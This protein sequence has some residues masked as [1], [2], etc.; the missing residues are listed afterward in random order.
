MIDIE[1]FRNLIEARE[2]KQLRQ[3]INTLEVADLAEIIGGLQ[4]ER[5]FIIAFRL[6]KRL[7]RA[8]V[9][10]NLPADSQEKL[11]AIF[12]D[13]IISAFVEEM[14][15]DD[16]TRLLE[17]V[18]SE[19]AERFIVG[20]SPNEQRIARM[21]LSYPADS[22][23]RLMT[24]DFVT[25]KDTLDVA[26]ALAQVRWVAAGLD[27]NLLY[28]ILVTDKHGIYRGSLSLPEL[29]TQDPTS[30]LIGDMLRGDYLTLRANDD[31]ELAV[32]NFRKYDCDFLPVVDN[33]E[34]L[35]G[36]VTADDVFDVAE[37]EATEDM[38]QF[39]GQER[40]DTDYFKTPIFT[41]IRK[42]AG[43]L[44]IL[45]VG[46]L[47]TGGALKFYDTFILQMGFIIYF[48]PLVISTGGNSGTQSAALIIR[49]LAI[50]EMHLRDWLKVFRREV[51]IGICLGTLLGVMGYLRSMTWDYSWK[52]SL[53][54][55]STIMSVV[56]FGALLGSMLPFLF[57]K[58]KL[59]PAV[60]SSPFIASLVD[61][62]GVIV[63]INI[64][65]LLL[66]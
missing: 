56:I 16:R 23:G 38:Q 45:F 40:L 44:A 57:K 48:I 34:K 17:S 5:E 28:N 12:P 65:R 55:F 25:V 32:D 54:I 52:I 3:I 39:G 26:S 33:Q 37:E 36:I 15:P 19:I 27:K 13:V 20:L 31:R 60:V 63:L 14:N 9:F 61:L 35:Q 66:L 21:L 24:T 62:F 43:W 53:V 11:L 29:V 6:L 18:P 30:T 46:E 7:E 2:F 50:R 41:M 4:E 42:R 59:D 10:A 64:A 1:L 51:V 49:G 8:A 47:F 58:I 22:I